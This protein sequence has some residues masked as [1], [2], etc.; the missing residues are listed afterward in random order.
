M[1]SASLHPLRSYLSVFFL[2]GW[3]GLVFIP[4]VLS[5]ADPRSPNVVIILADD[6]GYAD[7]GFQPN[8]APDVRTPNIDALA[9]TGV[10]FSNGYVSG[11][12]CATTRAGLLTG[13]YQQRFGFYQNGDARKGI[14]PSELTIGDVL[15]K[16]G[17]VTGVFGKWHV[18]FG[19][20]DHPLERGFDSFYGFMAGGAHDYWDLSPERGQLHNAL[21][22]DD[23]IIDDTGRGYLT[24]ILAEEAVSFI[25]TN[26][27]QPFLLY[28]PFNAVHEPK[29][30]RERDL[31]MFDTGNGN[32]NVLLAMIWRMDFAI[33]RVVEAL[34]NAGVYEDTLL[35]FLSDNGGPV[36]MHAN[37]R[38]LN[39][40]KHT[41][42]EGGVRVPFFVSWPARFPPGIREQPVISLDILPTALA[43]AGGQLP[44]DREY[45]GRNLLPLLRGETETIGDRCLFFDD[46]TDEWAVREGRWKLYSDELGEWDLYD[47]QGNVHLYDLAND[48][49]EQ[50]D[51]F[52]QHPDIVR[53]LKSAVKD[54]RRG[55]APPLTPPAEQIVR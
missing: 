29:Q 19:R 7:A 33:G 44:E 9:E 47:N 17:Y 34:H 11:N 25:K 37:N 40:H 23:E 41:F 50:K 54:W 30:A 18:G 5:A 48:I 10:R 39:G 13:R 51:L 1:N 26:R 32:R 27:D 46:H 21:Y 14:P 45:D 53:R 52:E 31:E 24:D 12:V 4:L 38:P 15:R 36:R 16:Q 2:V 55:L 28:L 20:D 35:F 6:L 3:V 42:Y 43:A 49:G 22:R 8:R